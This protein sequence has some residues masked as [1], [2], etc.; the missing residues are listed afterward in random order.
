MRSKNLKAQYD[1]LWENTKARIES[2][3]L[4]FDA[5]L[6]DPED[7][8]FGIGL[9]IRPEKNVLDEIQK[10]CTKISG[11]EPEQYFYSPSDVHITILSIISCYEGFELDQIDIKKYIETIAPVLNRHSRFQI[12]FEG[13]TAS[14]SAVL[15]QG[16]PMGDTLE[17]IRDEIR[18]VFKQSTLEHSIDSRY[19]LETAHAT[20]IR[21][22]KPILNGRRLLHEL[23]KYR[24][25]PF[26]PSEVAHVELVFNDW[27]QR[28]AKVRLLKSFK[29]P[30]E[31]L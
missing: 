31:A 3:K 30:D 26:G 29:L 11:I 2:G 20:V 5:H 19:R 27:Y 14:D 28:A 13:I 8:R 7:S 22:R 9:R 12:Q 1:L 24:D 18:R 21:F 4:N 25:H 15:I 10:F 23:Q 16:F 6:D 17:A